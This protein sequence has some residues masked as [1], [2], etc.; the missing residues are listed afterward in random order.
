MRWYEW[1]RRRCGDGD[2]DGDGGGGGGGG[3]GTPLGH[4]YHCLALALLPTSISTILVC[5]GRVAP[6]A[7]AAVAAA[8]TAVAVVDEKGG[9]YVPG[10]TVLLDA[11]TGV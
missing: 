1:S 4:T 10:M 9:M 5:K 8:V 7:A 2:G 3:G 6:I 11:S